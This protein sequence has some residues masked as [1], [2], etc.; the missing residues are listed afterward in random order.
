MLRVA[1]LALT[2]AVSPSA[3]T[4]PARR[5]VNPPSA[6]LTLTLALAANAEHAEWIAVPWPVP[7]PNLMSAD[8]GD[9]RR[10]RDGGEHSVSCLRRHPLQCHIVANRD[11]AAIGRIDGNSALTAE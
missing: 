5:R 7:P 8:Q 6:R 9:R 10:C 3:R 4:T 11:L 2:H 1:A